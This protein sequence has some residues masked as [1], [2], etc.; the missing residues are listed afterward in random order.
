ME[1]E[2]VRLSVC[3]LKVRVRAPSL[4]LFVPVENSLN[5]FQVGHVKN[6]PKN[7]KKLRIVHP[8][9]CVEAITLNEWQKEKKPRRE[10][11][12]PLIRF[13]TCPF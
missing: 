1:A 9:C 3:M 10:D 8:I 4:V 2:K 13:Q 5:C 6:A 11:K 7:N 12:S